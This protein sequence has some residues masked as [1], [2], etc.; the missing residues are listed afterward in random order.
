LQSPALVKLKNLVTQL[1]EVIKQTKDATSAGK[2][3]IPTFDKFSSDLSKCEEGCKSMVRILSPLD[4][5]DDKE[6]VMKLETPLL[7][8]GEV[9]KS[10]CPENMTP[11]A[12]EAGNDDDLV[13]MDSKFVLSPSSSSTQNSGKKRIRRGSKKFFVVKKVR[14]T[15][16]S[17]KVEDSNEKENVA[18]EEENDVN[19]ENDE[20]EYE[21]E[22]IVDYKK[23]Q[24]GL[25]YR[26]RWRNYKAEEDTWEPAENLTSCGDVYRDFLQLKI[27]EKINAFSKG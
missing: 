22:H 19:D 8:N 6:K 27:R 15:L 18:A 1:G 3:D 16:I 7:T 25:V 2:A 24:S 13:P 9:V 11:P 20:E 10:N 5:P 26:V 12:S 23:K 21:V 14:K 4:D 17:Q